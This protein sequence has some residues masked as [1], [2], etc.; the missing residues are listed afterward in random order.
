MAGSSTRLLV[1]GSAGSLFVNSE[2]TVRLYDT[3][4]VPAEYLGIAKAQGNA[5]AILRNFSDVQWKFFSPAVVFDVE[6]PASDDVIYG[7]EQFILNKNQESYISYET[8]TNLLVK[9]IEEGRFIRQRFTA[10]QN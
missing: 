1:V 6:G 9:E 10:V 3:P 5:I 7:T 8:Y 4:E 2:R